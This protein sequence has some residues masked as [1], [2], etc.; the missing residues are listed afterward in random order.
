MLLLYLVITEGLANRLNL[1]LQGLHLRGRSVG[2]VGERK[3]RHFE[4]ERH[5]QD[6]HTKISNQPENGVDQREHRF[7]DEAEPA[8][9]DHEI[10]PIE[11]ERLVIAVEDRN[12]LGAGE[13][14]SVWRSR[15]RRAQ[16]LG[17]LHIVGLIRLQGAERDGRKIPP[18]HATR[19][20]G[21]QDRPPS[22]CR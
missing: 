7:G 1:R 16:R 13:Q 19:R 12:F 17:L 4:H 3:E 15:S 22:I 11:V 9:I 10:E 21:E 2:F 6:R 18:G 5:R 20:L 14:P 8:P